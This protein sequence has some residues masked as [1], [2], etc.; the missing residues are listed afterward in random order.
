VTLGY[1]V[2]LKANKYCSNIYVYVS[3]TNLF[4][5]TGYDG[6]DPELSNGDPLSSGIDWRDK[7]PT[8]RTFTFGAKF[9]F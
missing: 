9:T 3:G 1:N 7:Y 4:T 8:I 2:P 5:I 6:L